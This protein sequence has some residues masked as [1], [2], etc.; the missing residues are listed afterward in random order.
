MYCCG[1][2]NGELLKLMVSEKLELLVTIDRNL[3]FQQNLQ[4]AGVGILLLVAASNRA[5]D[6]LP[7]MPKLRAALPSA[8][9]GQIV[10]IRS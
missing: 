6:L 7:L 5:A 2:R 3:K 1:T 4:N 9:P 8:L 10:E